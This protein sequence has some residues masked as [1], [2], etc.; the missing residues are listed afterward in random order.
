M[1]RCRLLSHLPN[2]NRFLESIP[3]PQQR[4]QSNIRCPYLP[5]N[6]PDWPYNKMKRLNYVL[7]GKIIQGN[8]KIQ[9]G[10]LLNQHHKLIAS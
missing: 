2:Y 5:Q 4:S 6:A 9:I 8:K 10:L 3:P 1:V 7:I